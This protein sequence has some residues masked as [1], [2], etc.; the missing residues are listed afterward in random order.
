LSIFR[1]V[2]VVGVHRCAHVMGAPLIALVL[3][4]LAVLLF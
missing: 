4:L 3:G 1:H 2:F